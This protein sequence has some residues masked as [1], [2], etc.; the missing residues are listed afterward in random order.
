MKHIIIILFSVLCFQRLQAQTNYT[1][2]YDDLNRLV[3]VTYGN[4]T[5]IQYTYNELHNRTAKQVTGSST[6]LPD[7][8]PSNAVL[9]SSIVGTGGTTTLTWLH[10]NLGTAAAS[11]FVSN[12][13][14]ST[15]NTW[16][17]TDISLA[18]ENT[19]ALSGGVNPSLSKTLTIPVSTTVG[20]YYILVY[21][22]KNNSI[23]EISESNNVLAIPITVS[24]CGSFTLSNPSA[25]AATCGQN[26]GTASITATGGTAP[27][28]YTWNT[29]PVQNTAIASN[30]SAGTY[31]VNVSDATGC[32]QNS[33]MSV[34]SGAGLAVPSF[35]YSTSGNVVTFSNSSS[36]ATAYTWNFGNG[37]NSTATNPSA[38]YSTSGNYTVCLSAN[39]STCG[40]QNYCQLIN[41]SGSSSCGT[42]SGISASAISTNTANLSWTGVS[43]ADN[44]NLLYRP[45]GTSQWQT[46]NGIGNTTSYILNSLVANTSY[47]VQVQAVCSGLLGNFS[48]SG[49]FSTGISV[50]PYFKQYQVGTNNTYDVRTL[51]TN[52]GYVL[53]PARVNI[54]NKTNAF[55]YKINTQNGAIVTAKEFDTANTDD[56]LLRGA[57]TND[58]GAIL[59]VSKNYGITGQLVVKYNASLDIDFAK[60]ITTSGVPSTHYAGLDRMVQANDGG[61]FMFGEYGTGTGTRDF[62]I[63]KY[64]SAMVL[65][66]AKRL[67]NGGNDSWA[68]TAILKTTDNG[69][70]LQIIRYIDQTSNSDDYLVKITEN[71]TVSW[72]KRYYPNNG[73]SFS[74]N[75]GLLENNTHYFSGITTS[76]VTNTSSPQ[77]AMLL[78]VDKSN[79]NMI[80]VKH[81]FANGKMLP[82]SNGNIMINGFSRLVTIDANGTL[83]NNTKVQHSGLNWMD[84]IFITPNGNVVGTGSNSGYNRTAL[85]SFDSNLSNCATS[86][87]A[88]S[89][90]DY[91]GQSAQQT[92][93]FTE[94]GITL[95]VASY[96]NF[97]P[98]NVIVTGTD[99]CTAACPL[100]GIAP[101]STTICQG[102]TVNFYS[103]STGANTYSWRVGTGTSFSTNSSAAYTFV[104][105]GSNIVY[106]DVSN[107]SCTQTAQITVTVN[108]A[109]TIS[110]VTA[111]QEQCGKANGTATVTVAPSGSA[112]SWSN[113]GTAATIS[114]LAAG[115]YSVFATNTNGCA[116]TPQTVAVTNTSNGFSTFANVS[117]ITCFGLVNGSIA[118]SHSNTIGAITYAWSN[119]TTVNPAVNLAKGNY[120]VTISDAAGCS[121]V[122]TYTII[123]PSALQLKLQIGDVTDCGLT[124]GTATAIALGGTPPINYNWSNGQTSGTAAGLVQANY[125][126][127]ITDSKGCTDN[128]TATVGTLPRTQDV[129]TIYSN[130]YLGGISNAT[131][132]NGKIYLMAGI[133]PQNNFPGY[134]DPN[135]EFYKVNLINDMGVVV[136]VETLGAS[137][138]LVH[139]YVNVS[140][141]NKLALCYEAPTGTM[142]GFKGVYKRYDINHTL[143]INENVATNANWFAWMRNI[144]TPNDTITTRMLSFAHAGY[145]PMIH[146]RKQNGTWQTLVL[147]GPNIYLGNL[148]AAKDNLTNAVHL[149]GRQ[150][151]GTQTPTLRYYKV[152]EAVSGFSIWDFPIPIQSNCDLKMTPS[153][154]ASLLYFEDN[155][156]KVITQSATTW[157]IENLIYQKG[158]EHRASLFYRTNGQALVA[159]QTDEKVVVLQKNI[160]S[161]AW[162]VYFA[163]NNLLPTD[164]V[165]GTKGPTLLIEC[166]DLHVVYNDGKNVY[167]MNL[168]RPCNFVN[169][170]AKVMLQGAY[171]TTTGLMT[172]NLRTLNLIPTTEPY[173]GMTGFTHVGGGGEMVHSSV[174]VTTGNDAIV[175]WVF[176]E[177]RDKNNPTNILATRS[178]LLQRDGDVV[179]CDGISPVIFKNIL[180]GNYFLSAKH[181]NHLTIRSSITLEL[182][183]LN[184][185]YDF[186]NIQ[187]KAYQN[188]AIS[189]NTAMKDLG[190]NKFGLWRGNVNSDASVNVVDFAITKVASTPNQSSV[191][192]RTDVNMDG[193]INVADP[194]IVKSQ[195]TPNKSSHN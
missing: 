13:Y 170:T 121:Q 112:I 102:N 184:Q 191:Y 33:T 32:L 47:E 68:C 142:Y 101:I 140:A 2:T 89:I 115:T 127:T 81:T 126:V 84:D 166:G 189:S 183:N 107:G 120:V 116:S 181:R 145:Y 188:P 124:N 35:T 94:I 100:A 52:D 96:T 77:D 38:T 162:E 110:S 29:Q 69:F 53:Q 99:V 74:S 178:A 117:N 149:S 98:A 27:Y 57:P 143:G 164:Y 87:E 190:N 157:N 151:Y 10:N 21:M 136:P 175:D 23:V 45:T 194:A 147:Q 146:K 129:K 8:A 161:G 92:I 186:T 150:G 105:N 179:D 141:D 85:L 125:L 58:N 19:S 109:P 41:I 79:G 114:N 76:F 20:A 73:T 119:S 30:L 26:N 185:I 15:N 172:D 180:F 193:N 42:P 54:N 132:F 111:T 154:F 195:S 51:I 168:D 18:T 130:T 14:L 93:S 118:L 113:G 65:S 6:A 123:E 9:S 37:T 160:T 173:T 36:N 31:T 22:D 176:L 90:N 24:N 7:L 75:T 137:A 86:A 106:L 182:N 40:S 43:G 152:N 66:W 82:I 80:W 158:I 139:G 3:K 131:L 148:A 64:N 187:S 192:Q 34:A 104:N 122:K 59:K 61:Y 70:L 156:L 25:Q 163:H 50:I 71:G 17:A 174:F 62:Y 28:T 56:E 134:P 83:I 91:T 108:A 138:S 177:L 97:T 169:V 55:L 11:A 78:K 60:Q 72:A 135:A 95:N 12:V 39:N 103:T 67:S 155:T 167:K 88:I 128:G 63:A 144:E 5:V 165:G 48:G 153:N 171:N 49:Y 4:G 44:Y 1:Y 46:L 16:D 133:E 159:Y